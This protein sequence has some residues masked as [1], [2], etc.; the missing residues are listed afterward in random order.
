MVKPY[1]LGRHSPSGQDGDRPRRSVGGVEFSD[2]VRRRHMVRSYQDRPVPPS[3]LDRLLAAATRAPSAGFTQGW[4]F[5]VLEGREQTALFWDHTLPAE[6]RASF[7]W[8]GLLRAPV[9]VLPLASRQAYLDRYAEPDKAGSGLHE[10][11]AWRVPYW[12][13]DCAFAT[14]LLLLAATDAGLGAL[15]FAVLRGEQDLLA[16]L[17][18]PADHHPIGA[19]ALGYPAA[20]DRPSTSVARGRRPLQAVVHRGGW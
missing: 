15:F 9:L 11:S 19:V 4:A 8:P 6:D 16:D 20:D 1:R 7:A 5:V 10:A 3:V 17:G 13:V 12:Q 2:A 18:V 14:M